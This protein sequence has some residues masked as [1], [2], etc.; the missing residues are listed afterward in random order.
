VR[1]SARVEFLTR[2]LEAEP[3]ED[4]GQEHIRIDEN[5]VHL[6]PNRRT[7]QNLAVPVGYG[8]VSGP[9]LE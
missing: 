9:T 2:V 8:A 1:V 3:E 6:S 7:L 5:L 4:H